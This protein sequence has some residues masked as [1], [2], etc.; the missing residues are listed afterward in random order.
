M[1]GGGKQ[2]AYDFYLCLHNCHKNFLHGKGLEISVEQFSVQ[3][4][5]LNC[6]LYFHSCHS[7]H[8]AIVQHW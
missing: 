6:D 7:S 4:S 2:K 8:S 5:F 3:S 1:G